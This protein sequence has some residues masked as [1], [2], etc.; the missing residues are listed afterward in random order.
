MKVFGYRIGNFTY[1]TDANFISEEE[2]DKIVGSEILVLNGLR[3]EPHPSHFTFDQALALIARI[4]PKAAYLTHISHQ[5]GTHKEVTQ[6]LPPNVHL[7]YD[8]L[9]LE[10][11]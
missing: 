5:L 4:N 8:G 2:I 7:A 3:K 1:I 10:L 11:Q 6:E 9:T